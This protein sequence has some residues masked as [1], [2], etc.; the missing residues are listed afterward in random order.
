MSWSGR[1]LGCGWGV[2]S[3]TSCGLLGERVERVTLYRFVDDEAA[4][5]P[6]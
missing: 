2:S 4:D 5:G 6:P 3:Q 1:T